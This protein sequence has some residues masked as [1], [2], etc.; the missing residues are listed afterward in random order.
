M[1]ETVRIQIPDAITENYDSLENLQQGLYEDIVISE[2]QRGNLSIREC[3]DILQLTYEGFLEFLGERNL[4]FITASKTDLEKSY[5]K[6]KH[7]Y[8]N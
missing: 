8:S 7:S 2:F 3:A 6:Y 5:E 4:S 1:P